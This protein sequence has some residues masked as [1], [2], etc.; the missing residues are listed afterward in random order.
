MLA[1]LLIAGLQPV[2]AK[3]KV[4]ELEDSIATLKAQYE[5]LKTKNSN[6]IKEISDLE[7]DTIVIKSTITQRKELLESLK[8][9]KA[10]IEA[11]KLELQNYNVTDADSE[12]VKNDIDE[13]KASFVEMATAFLYVPYNKEGISKI[14]IPA[15]ELSKGSSYYDDYK[16]RLTLLQNYNKNTDQLIKY[17]DSSLMKFEDMNKQIEK[18]NIKNAQSNFDKIKSDFF[19]LSCFEEYKSYGDGWEETYLGEIIKGI[20]KLLTS[21]SPAVKNDKIEKAFK[22]FLMK[23]Q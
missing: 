21:D 15:F 2:S 7:H 11:K 16:I 22:D 5:T 23:L 14:A 12:K 20:E 1:L 19:K 4:K 9:K 10:S 17:L 13:Y 3:D 18:G 6:L 8:E